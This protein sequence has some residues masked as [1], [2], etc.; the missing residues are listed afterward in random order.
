MQ[1]IEA[2]V[3]GAPPVQQVPTGLPAFAASSDGGFVAVC[4]KTRAALFAEVPDDSLPQKLLGGPV[5]RECTKALAPLRH[6]DA[7]SVLNDCMALVDALVAKSGNAAN[8]ESDALMCT[9][10]AASLGGEKPP[11]HS[12]TPAQATETVSPSAPQLR[13]KTPAVPATTIEMH[14][15]DAQS[16]LHQVANAMGEVCSETVKAVEKGVKSEGDAMRISNTVS[17]ACVEQARKRFGSLVDTTAVAPSVQEWC[18]QLD[19]RFTLALETGFFF[20]LQPDEA[21][22]QAGRPN[23][24]ATATRR[25]FCDRFS[26]YAKTHV[27]VVVAPAVVAAPVRKET[28]A[29]RPVV[30]NNKAK[31]A[32]AA[33][34]N[35]KVASSVPA[36]IPVAMHALANTVTSE[37]RTIAVATRKGIDM[38]H[39]MQMISARSEWSSACNKLLAGIASEEGSVTDSQAFGN[40]GLTDGAEVLTFN[41]VDQGEIDTCAATFKGLAVEAGAFTEAAWTAPRGATSLLSLGSIEALQELIESPWARDACGDVVRGFLTM[42][43]AHHDVKYAEFCQA[44]AG[45]LHNLHGEKAP[46]KIVSDVE[47]LRQRAKEHLKKK[48]RV[49]D[50]DVHSAPA[51]LVHAEPHSQHRAAAPV[52]T[53]HPALIRA[54]QQA[55]PSPRLMP[56]RAAQV[57]AKEAA[58]AKSPPPHK[59]AVDRQQPAPSLPVSHPALIRATIQN[60]VA[61]QAK[62]SPRVVPAAE[63]VVAMP[64]EESTVAVAATQDSESPEEQEEE[65]AAL[66]RGGFN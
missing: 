51:V 53:S 35:T 38:L 22:K 45:S 44:Y 25:Q 16:E 36:P 64:Q 4:E 50:N 7:E 46:T 47:G 24:Y 15:H 9:N 61:P 10:L 65:G 21:A 14:A 48:H 42:R 59:A 41:T 11:T 29:A 62:D 66:W 39:L 52:A 28:P 63:P 13:G 56:R 6:D 3:F 31:P 20:A 30:A 2:V 58:K 19:G 26:T 37:K 60:V 1:E 49:A 12:Q 5:Y 27:K 23:P 54:T 18:D 40:A 8:S 32:V 34:P 55:L 57:V 17:P 43:L 33:V